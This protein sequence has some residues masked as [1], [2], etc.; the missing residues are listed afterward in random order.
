MQ[1]MKI[2]FVLLFI[3]CTR[4]ASKDKKPIVIN[5]N[6]NEVVLINN[7]DFN[8]NYS[9]TLLGL[10]KANHDSFNEQKLLKYAVDSLLPCWYGTKWDFNG[11][12]TQPQK[13]AIACGYFVTTVLQDIGVRINRIKLAQCP[14]SVLIER[15]CSNIS[16]Y[17]NKPLQHFINE[18]KTKGPGLY[19][20]GLDNHTGFICN[21]GIDIYFI[22][23]SYY[24][25]K[26]VVKERAIES[27]PLKNSK[28]RMIGKINF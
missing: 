5:Q 14:S 2:F 21:D 19:I 22:H 28:F 18:V 25:P 9:K 1:I 23:S 4:T 12:T 7:Y 11:T 15:T 10:L 24:S 6:R 16:R 26:A 8:K 17:S 13:G 27:L 20:T 3:S